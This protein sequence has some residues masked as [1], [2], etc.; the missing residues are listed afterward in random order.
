MLL[1]SQPAVLRAMFS[2]TMVTCFGA[3]DGTIT[4]SNPSGGS[5]TFEFSIDGGLTW[6]SSGSFHSLPPSAY[7]LM[8]RDAASPACDMILNNAVD[9]T[10]PPALSG[11]IVKS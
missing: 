4:F 5:G 1:I 7:S 11:T 3:D 2:T 9:I 6:Q 10:E 8:I